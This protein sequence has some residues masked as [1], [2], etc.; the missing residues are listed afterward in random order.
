MGKPSP[1]R[2]TR[3][4]RGRS[5]ARPP[6]RRPP[7]ARRPTGSSAQSTTR[8]WPTSWPTA[9]PTWPKYGLDKPVLQVKFLSVAS[10]NTAESNA[11]AKAIATVDFGRT[12]GTDVFAR[13]E[14]EPF[15]VSVPATV[16]DSIASDPLQWQDVNIFQADPEK[17]SSLEITA[18]GR[19]E[20]AL[21]RAGQGRLDAEQG[22]G[23][24]GRGEGAV[25]REHAGPLARRPLGGRGTAPVWIGHPGGDADVRHGRRSEGRR[26]VDARQPESRADGL[27]PRGRPR[28]RVPHQPA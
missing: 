28:R 9:P 7:T 6:A 25:H 19:P 16:M 17:V 4:R 18:P 27:C 26:Q 5:S 2:T 24:V 21:T 10:E 8:K 3:T 20:V 22:R 14:E 11:G 13:V 15:V 1:S 23:S 12:E